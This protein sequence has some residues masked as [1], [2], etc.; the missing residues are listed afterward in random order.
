MK[1]ISR[2]MTGTTSPPLDLWR[3]ADP[4]PRTT[5]L[6]LGGRLNLSSATIGL[7]ARDRPRANEPYDHAR[8]VITDW[9]AD[10]AWAQGDE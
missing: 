7:G 9:G 4:D 3:A 5:F 10:P 8:I 1:F 6:F 2:I